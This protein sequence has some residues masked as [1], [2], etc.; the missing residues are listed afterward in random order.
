MMEITAHWAKRT[1]VSFCQ[2]RSCAPAL[3]LHSHLGLHRPQGEC[4]HS[5]LPVRL[6][7]KSSQPPLPKPPTPSEQP[8]ASSYGWEILVLL[9][10][11]FRHL[12]HP[13][14]SSPHRSHPASSKPPP[15]GKESMS[16][17]T[18][19]QQC[20]FTSHRTCCALAHDGL[21]SRCPLPTGQL[22]LPQSSFC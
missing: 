14:R 16:P 18:V 11:F 7:G 19:T 2:V 22:A 5:I 13:A 20:S 3:C 12:V 1:L 10:A 21:L 17:C 15:M 9:L 6:G 8:P 4:T